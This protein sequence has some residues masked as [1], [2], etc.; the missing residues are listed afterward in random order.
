M[1]TIK[2]HNLEPSSIFWKVR[3]FMTE[4]DVVNLQKNHYIVVRPYQNRPVKKSYGNRLPR[5]IPRKLDF[6]K[7]P[8]KD[9]VRSTY[10]NSEKQEKHEQ[11]TI[12][13][14]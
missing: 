11:R 13:A 4:K 2:L 5:T 12:Y 10:S 7:T 1:E 9:F 6:F 3:F 14:I 8:K